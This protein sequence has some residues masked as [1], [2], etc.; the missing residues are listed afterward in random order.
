MGAEISGNGSTQT[1]CEALVSGQPSQ[2]QKLSVE[3]SG[4]G[5]IPE[6]LLALV[7]ALNPGIHGKPRK[8]GLERVKGIEPSFL[9][10]QAKS[11]KTGAK[12]RDFVGHWVQAYD[13]V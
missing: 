6:D 10:E 13:T 12:T 2:G 11:S 9:L 1:A 5:W 4:R 3:V 7:L 8:R